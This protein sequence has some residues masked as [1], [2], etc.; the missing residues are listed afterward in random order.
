MN[1]I[2]FYLLTTLALTGISTR[3]EILM[4]QSGD[5][6]KRETQLLL[7]KLRDEKLR[8]EAPQEVIEAIDRL[9]ELRAQ[10]AIS[11]L[12]SLLAFRQIFPWERDSSLPIQEIHPITTS[13]RYPATGALMQIGK[14]A[15]QALID[16]LAKKQTGTLESENALYVVQ[17]IFLNDPQEGGSYLREAAAKFSDAR[18]RDRLLNAAR[19]LN[20]R[21]H[22]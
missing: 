6:V 20:A 11:D 3:R 9:G 4:S 1:L 14:P 16:V 5:S 7:L 18:S 12:V 17:Q 10:D 8:Q 21:S 15:L 22:K 13:G 19:Q 2:F